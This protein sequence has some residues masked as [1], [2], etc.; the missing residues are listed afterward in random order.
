[1]LGYSARQNSMSYSANFERVH[2]YSAL[3]DDVPGLDIANAAD[4]EQPKADE[5]HP[6]VCFRFYRAPCS[7]NVMPRALPASPSLQYWCFRLWERTACHPQLVA[8]SKGSP[9]VVLSSSI[10]CRFCVHSLRGEN[11]SCWLSLAGYLL[12][13]AKHLPGSPAPVAPR[14]ADQHRLCTL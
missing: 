7:P 9:V 8:F 13:Y 12:E 10:R 14:C 11:I 2:C 1:M 5:G 6:E 4:V 3:R